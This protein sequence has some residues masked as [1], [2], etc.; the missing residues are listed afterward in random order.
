MK[1]VAKKKEIA[2]N[3][4][5]TNNSKKDIQKKNTKIEIVD[6]EKVV[7]NGGKNSVIVIS[8]TKDDKYIITFQNRL[9]NTKIA[10]F[11]S[12]YIEDNETPI[13]A[14]K[15]ELKEETGYLSNSLFIVD[16]VFTSPGIDNSITYI[17]IATNCIKTDN[18]KTDGNEL[19]NYGLFNEM[20]LKY[21]IGSNIM[22]GAMNKLAYYNLINNVDNCNIDCGNVYIH[23]IRK[24][25]ITTSE[26][27]EHM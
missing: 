27:L 16:K 5:K 7:K 8:I 19:V 24:N 26:C 21:L 20:E 3:K 22:N 6:K 18:I 2:E 15:R 13:M 12:G 23:K 11:P 10:E 9:K 25:H 1:T 4:Q 17:V 14:A